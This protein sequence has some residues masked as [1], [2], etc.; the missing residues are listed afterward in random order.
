[1]T[2]LS[3]PYEQDAKKSVCLNPVNYVTLMKDYVIINLKSMLYFA[4]S[5]LNQ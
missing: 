3:I 2:G 1:M 5:K 4:Y